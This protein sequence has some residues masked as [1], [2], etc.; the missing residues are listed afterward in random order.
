[1]EREEIIGIIKSF[2]K[3]GLVPSRGTEAYTFIGNFVNCFEHALL[4]LNNKQLSLLEPCSETRNVFGQLRQSSPDLDIESKS[5]EDNLYDFVNNVGLKIEPTQSV[6][7]HLARNQW[8]IAR[9][10]GLLGYHF[11]LQERDGTWSAK[12]GWDPS[13]STFYKLDEYFLNN[14]SPFAPK[15]QRTYI[16]TNPYAEQE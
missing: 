12:N 3:S 14:P 10:H 2:V 6:E 4:N 9:Y 1:M 11:A 7:I 13:I 16:I 15:F 5:V 8:I